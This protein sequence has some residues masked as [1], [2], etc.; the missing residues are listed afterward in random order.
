MTCSARVE[1]DSSFRWILNPKSKAPPAVTAVFRV[2]SLIFS[3]TA[4]PDAVF[5]GSVVVFK[6][7]RIAVFRP[8]LAKAYAA[9]RD[10]LQHYRA[11]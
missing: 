3:V 9:K 5:R 2:L 1:E 11:A 7:L 8:R 6:K 10:G 4:V